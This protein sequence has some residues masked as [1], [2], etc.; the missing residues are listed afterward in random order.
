VGPAA[1]EEGATGR[2]GADQATVLDADRGAWRALQP[3]TVL[4][5]FR[6][7]AL[8][9]RG[10][11]A[12]VYRAF[13]QS[14]QRS[15]ALKVLAPQLASE[16]GFVSRFRREGVQLA[17][18]QHEAIVT[19]Y[20]A[21]ADAGHLF[22]AM[23]LIDG[24]SLKERLADARVLAAAE[25]LAILERVGA[26]LDFA[27]RQGFL[28]RDVKPAN[29]LLDVEGQAY[30]ADFGL[31]KA[32]AQP[33]AS[34]SGNLVGTPIYMA[35]EQSAGKEL[36]G[37]A[38]LYSLACVAFECLTGTPPYSGEDI[39]VLLLAHAADGVPR[40]SLRNPALPSAVD[41]VF[42][43]ALAKDPAERHESVTAFLT[44]LRTALA[45]HDQAA[46]PPPETERRERQDP[47]APGRSG[48]GSTPAAPLRFR[49]PPVPLFGRESLVSQVCS[50][51]RGPH[52]RL[53]SL[54]G[55]GGVGKTRL[56]M[57][58]VSRLTPKWPESPV[59]IPLDGVQD[60]ELVIPTVGRSIGVRE[61]PG[62]DALDA[63]LDA[64][65]DRRALL[66]LDN[67]EHLVDAA[68]ALEAIIEGCPGVTLLVTSR[69]RLHVRAE[70]LLDVPPLP[71]PT[72]EAD[73][74]SL[75]DCSS[76]QMFADRCAAAGVAVGPSDRELTAAG[77]IC[78]RLDGLPLAL[79]LAAARSRL[80]GLEGICAQMADRLG[81][82]TGGPRDLPQRQQALRATIEWSYGLLAPSGQALLQRLGVFAGGFSVDAATD[83]C[84]RPRLEVVDSLAGLVDASLVGHATG[85]RPE[86]RL[87]LLQT[88]QDFALE[89]LE[90]DGGTTQTYLRHARYFLTLVEEADRGL[91]GSDQGHWLHVLGQERDNIRLALETTVTNGC[92]EEA[93]RLTAAM[94]RYWEIRGDLVEGR[95][96]SASALRLPGGAGPLRA[97]T[98]KAAGNLARD[99]AD[100]EVAERCHSEALAL[101]A[102]L[103]SPAQIAA[104]LNNL[105]NVA[106]D[107][108]DHG[109]SVA[110]YQRA[111][112]LLDGPDDTALR[113]LVEHNLALALH[114]DDPDR[115][116]DLLLR[117]LA[118]QEMIGDQCAVARTRATIG[119]VHLVKGDPARAADNQRAAVLLQATLGDLSTLS[120]S[121]EGLAA[122]AAAVG[123][124][125]QAACLL[126]AAEAVRDE[127]GLPVT[128]DDRGYHRAMAAVRAELDEES[129]RTA[130]DKGREIPFGEWLESV[131]IPG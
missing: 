55:P 115:A 72:E 61:G 63:V 10:A 40:T 117:S 16:P 14:L 68:S 18:L 56:A 66:A 67:F 1:G 24:T 89:R 33:G 102:E 37:R 42:H 5:G 31:I 12:S 9:G 71:V 103:G 74:A 129:L 25:A 34:T 100:H 30:L 97:Q 50:L 13:Q 48:A 54:V 126:G 119:L 92:V 17:R 23:Q 99:Q 47:A 39:V 111:L 38:D 120:R 52:V 7:E 46:P 20:D 57:E 114:E 84:A 43:R 11:T 41:A 128:T 19:V 108:G 87:R 49:G 36:T 122:S 82:L 79:E 15:V 113:A 58:V 29:I 62:Q 95:R 85:E 83:V 105:G 8:L 78:R 35:P 118:R 4:A 101:F 75:L 73:R 88:V 123:Q 80:L 125:V 94:W 98:L 59:F 131:A 116:L 91:Q 27:H 90:A 127:I 130:W 109:T 77:E 32:L 121:L 70:R 51:L 112:E 86:G 26:G 2:L 93:L 64:L 81:L 107:Q 76:V 44:E 53:L 106:L 3:G 28:H 110:R 69:V 45:A 65:E 124:P 60:P 22:L 104:C 96:W 6:V 21:G